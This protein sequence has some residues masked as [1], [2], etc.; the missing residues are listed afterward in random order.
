MNEGKNIQ[1]VL[2]GFRYQLVEL[3]INVTVID[4]NSTDDTIDNAKA[5]GV[6]VIIQRTRGK[7]AAIKEALECLEADLFVFIDGDGT[8]NPARLTAS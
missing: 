1:R 2:T 5:A 3:D 7:G 6:D 8:Y 4:G